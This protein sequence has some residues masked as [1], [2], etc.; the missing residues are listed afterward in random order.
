MNIRGILVEPGRGRIRQI[1]VGAIDRDGWRRLLECEEIREV[2]LPD[3]KHRLLVDAKGFTGR[4]QQ[5][6]GFVL[7]KRFHAG[8]G[9]IIGRPEY[10]HSEADYPAVKVSFG[11]FREVGL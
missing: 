5:T 3:G 10:M 2:E 9:L 11:V 8:N 1:E 7:G 6:D 4:R